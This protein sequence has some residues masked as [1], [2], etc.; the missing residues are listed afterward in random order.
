MI[1]KKIDPGKPADYRNGSNG[2]HGAFMI[3]ILHSLCLDSYGRSPFQS[4][5]RQG[6]TVISGTAFIV[7]P[8]LFLTAR[9]S[10]L[11]LDGAWPDNKDISRIKMRLYFIH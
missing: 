5:T 1:E 6:L 3:H 11:M 7:L 10:D 8:F 2:A 4:K 9:H